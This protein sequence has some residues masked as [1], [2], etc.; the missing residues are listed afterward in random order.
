MAV[1]PIRLVS[2]AA[3][4]AVLL[5]FAPPLPAQGPGQPPKR[6]A[7]KLDAVLPLLN[8]S[9]VRVRPAGSDAALT[10]LRIRDDET[11]VWV[12]GTGAL[13]QTYESGVF[14]TWSAATVRASAPVDRF[15]LLQTTG[16]REA[17][18]PL[19]PVLLK[20]PG[21]VVAAAGAG[22]VLDVQTVWVDPAEPITLPAGAA[23]FTTDGKLAGVVTES[24]GK[25]TL[26]PGTEV[27]ARAGLLAA[28]AKI[29]GAPRH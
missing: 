1:S 11:L 10:G 7:P 2:G 9:L 17:A 16:H 22:K 21:F 8:A 29:Q 14:D 13:P 12:P 20:A 19:E 24:S 5:A 18:R 15:V 23:V 27:L 3:L 6:I 28:Q 25:R 26:I 4:A